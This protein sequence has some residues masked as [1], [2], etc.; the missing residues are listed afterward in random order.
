MQ[1]LQKAILIFQVVN[2]QTKRGTDISD[3]E[4]QSWRLSWIYFLDRKRKV[5]F[6]DNLDLLSRRFL[7]SRFLSQT[8]YIFFVFIPT[9]INKSWSLKVPKSKI[10]AYQNLKL[11]FGLYHVA[12]ESTYSVCLNF[13]YPSKEL[14]SKIALGEAG[15]SLTCWCHALVLP[16]PGYWRLFLNLIIFS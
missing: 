7:L 14:C 4:W 2:A 13:I 1:G 12:A 10:L 6:K 11:S 8:S 15:V 16:A 3:N 9:D 5:R